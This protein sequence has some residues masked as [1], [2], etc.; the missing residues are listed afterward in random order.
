MLTLTAD[1][2]SEPLG[3]SDAKAHLRMDDIDADDQVILALCTAA[4]QSAEKFTGLD[5]A[6]KTWEYRIDAFPASR[7]PLP[8][9]PVRSIDSIEYVDTAGANATVN[10]AVYGL[11]HTEQSPALFLQYDQSWPD[12]RA[13]VNAV[14][15]TLQTGYTDAPA[16]IVHALKMI[17]SELYKNRSISITTGAV[18]KE[19]PMAARYLLNQYRR[20]PL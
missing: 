11:D 4:R 19:V 3:L 16:P 18:P 5:L 13:Q 15:I 6:G 8:L 1:A 10:A 9:S 2:T 14:T 12:A 7:I 17:V 20:I